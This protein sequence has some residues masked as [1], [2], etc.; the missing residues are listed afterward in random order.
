M[1]IIEIL[2]ILD[3]EYE[4][5]LKTEY[6]TYSKYLKDFAKNKWVS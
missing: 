1:K 3:K 4:D 6:P 5:Y 2:M